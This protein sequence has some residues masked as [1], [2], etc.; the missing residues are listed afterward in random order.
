MKHPLCGPDQWSEVTLQ[1]PTAGLGLGGCSGSGG[2]GYGAVVFVLQE[3]V[4]RD[5]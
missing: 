3:G 1:L 2:G 4:G 5:V